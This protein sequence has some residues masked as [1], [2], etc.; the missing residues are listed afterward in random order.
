[1]VMLEARVSFPT[2]ITSSLPY[3]ILRFR[4]LRGGIP[5]W[6]LID[7]QAVMG[8]AYGN[9]KREQ[10]LY[11]TFPHD[12]GCWDIMRRCWHVDPSQRE[13]MPGLLQSLNVLT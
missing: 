2:Y 5:F 3:L 6:Y 7:V 13:E 11:P 12:Q 4:L 9:E 8:V 10:N 1:M